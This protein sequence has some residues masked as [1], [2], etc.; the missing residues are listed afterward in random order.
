MLVG[1]AL[2]FRSHLYPELDVIRAGGWTG[3]FSNCP[4]FLELGQLLESFAAAE[5]IA[6]SSSSAQGKPNSDNLAFT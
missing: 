6:E 2:L 5:H 1:N 3:I 4:T